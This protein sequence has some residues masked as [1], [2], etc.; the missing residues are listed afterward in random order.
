MARSTSP[1]FMRQ[2]VE[3]AASEIVD[4]VAETAG[5]LVGDE[6]EVYG[7]VA[8][9]GAEFAAYYLDLHERGVLDHLEVVSPRYARELR[10]RFEREA[11][12]VLGL[13]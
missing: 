8:L 12:R 2:V 1:E 3:Q 11:A 10:E 6:G 5:A 9:R 7:D 4:R 13:A